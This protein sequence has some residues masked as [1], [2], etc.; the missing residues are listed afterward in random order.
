[1]SRQTASAPALPPGSDVRRLQP[2]ARERRIFTEQG[3]VALDDL[4]DD[5]F[6]AALAGEARAR[7]QFA[8]LPKGGPRTPVRGDAPPPRRTP[9]ATGPLLAALH[10]AMV[11]TVRALCGRLVGPTFASYGYYEGDDRALLHLDTDQ[12]DVTLL[13]TA[14]GEVGPLHLHPDLRGRTMDEL[15]EL[16]GDPTW[17]RTGGIQVAYPRTG[18]MALSGHAIPHHR[19]GR[20]LSEPSAVAALCYRSLF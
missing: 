5:D 4:W 15:A 9:A 8:E 13:T 12:C 3:F 20:P 10:F 2:G 11:G 17:D 14:F 19:P 6:A 1:M 18:L 16:E 7:Q